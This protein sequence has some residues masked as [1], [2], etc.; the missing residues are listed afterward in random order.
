[1]KAVQA[2]GP[3][4]MGAMMSIVP[5]SSGILAIFIFKEAATIELI[6]GLILVSFGAWLAHSKLFKQP[7][8]LITST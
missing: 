5:V 6:T 4:S 7:S 3:S 1:M 8:A 2:I